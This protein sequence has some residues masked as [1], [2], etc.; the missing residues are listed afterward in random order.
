MNHTW[1]RIE[2]SHHHS[3]GRQIYAD[4]KESVP[5]RMTEFLRFTAEI[6]EVIKIISGELLQMKIYE[7]EGDEIGRPSGG[8][9]TGLAKK[10]TLPKEIV[11]FSYPYDIAWVDQQSS[12]LADNLKIVLP[13]HL[14][15]VF[16]PGDALIFMIKSESVIP[17]I[18]H[19]NTLFSYHVYLFNGSYSQYIEWKTRA[20]VMADMAARK[21]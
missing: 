5:G 14:P 13:S 6:D 4:W 1:K 8:L 15:L 7:A 2:L 16:H 17:A 20:G 18:P 9:I 11:Q 3:E 21:G 10:D 12:R 19:A